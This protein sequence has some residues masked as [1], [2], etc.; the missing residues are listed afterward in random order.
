MLHQ[1]NEVSASDPHPHPD[2]AP[3]VADPP[4]D[5]AFFTRSRS[6]IG[7][8]FDTCASCQ[9]VGH[10]GSSDDART[11]VHD[12]VSTDGTI[13]HHNIPCP[14]SD[15]I[16]LHVSISADL[17]HPG[18]ASRA[19]LFDFKPLLPVCTAIGWGAGLGGLGARSFGGSE[20]RWSR[21]RHIDVGHVG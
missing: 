3:Y 10:A 19:Y 16:P 9:R 6:L 20:G 18:E 13:I 14:Q 4:C 8:T 11:E 5:G 2:E 21:I 15:S 12:V 7:L 17:D 1:S